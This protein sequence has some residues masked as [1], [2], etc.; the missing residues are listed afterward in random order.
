MKLSILIPSLY[1]RLLQRML[2]SIYE[3]KLPESWEMEILIV[4]PHPI[5]GKNIVHVPEP[6]AHGTNPAMRAGYKA[7]TGDVIACLA[8]DMT[9]SKDCF[10]VCLGVLGVQPDTIVAMDGGAFKCFDRRWAICPMTL[11]TTVEKYWDFFFPYTSHWG[12]NAFSLHVTRMG[13]RVLGTPGGQVHWGLDR[14]GEGEAVHKTTAFA[15]DHAR[16]LKDFA[17]MAVGYDHK[18]WLSYTHT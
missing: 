15:D 1:P 7:S 14:M 17:E 10:S 16:F 5:S 11:R 8:D 6:E 4:S 13:G 18:D 2:A 3:N 12:D 9:V